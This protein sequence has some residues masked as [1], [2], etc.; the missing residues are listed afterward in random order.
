MEKKTPRF[1]SPTPSLRRA[2]SENGR[3]R[4]ETTEEFVNQ[5]EG[6]PQCEFLVDLALVV[7][8]RT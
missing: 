7:V 2:V 4:T 6:Q 5:A 1:A 8:R 3:F